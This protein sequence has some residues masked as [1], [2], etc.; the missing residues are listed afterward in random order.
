[1]I[2]NHLNL[3]AFVSVC[4]NGTVHSAAQALYLTQ[5]AVT[6]RIR[7]LERQLDVCLFIRSRQGMALTQEGERLLR[8]CK[9]AFELEK[10]A[11]DHIQ[12]C[13]S[14]LPVSLVIE[15]P[16][17]LLR[18]RLINDLTPLMKKFQNVLL[19]FCANDCENSHKKLLNG[20]IDFA[21]ISHEHLTRQMQRKKLKSES[22]VLVGPAAWAHRP[23]AEIIEHEKL[24][25]FDPLDHMSLRY[26]ERYH[27]L[28][29]SSPMRYFVNRT[30]LLAMMVVNALGY[31]TLTQEYAKPYI[32]S[33]DLVYLNQ[34]KKN[35]VTSYLAWFDRPQAPQYFR[36][37]IDL[38]S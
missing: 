35:E 7:S 23:L 15:G 14:S 3:K 36:D 30:D 1:M 29:E 17:S 5:T 32:D 33:G 11:I 8:Y 16:S 4:D 38:I 2:L 37:C 21:I 22:Y 26:L 10:E 20:D 24:I 19:R 34:G 27:L 28:P 31:T 9:G 13:G 6:Q 25:D 18:S 12:A